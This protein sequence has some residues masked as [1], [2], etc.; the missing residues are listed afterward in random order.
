MKL[1]NSFKSRLSRASTRQLGSQSSTSTGQT[2]LRKEHL[3]RAEKRVLQIKL[4]LLTGLLLTI[5]LILVPAPSLG[6]TQGGTR[7]AAQSPVFHQKFSPTPKPGAACDWNLHGNKL[8]QK[9]S[10]L[11][12]CDRG[13]WTWWKKATS[14][15]SG[16]QGS[17]NSKPD[18][19]P[20]QL[21]S[22][23]GKKV[24]SKSNGTLLCGPK[25]VGRVTTLVWYKSN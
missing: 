16:T 11:Y 18:V 2:I 4:A 9:G 8:V 17:S 5:Q 24:E 3:T 20:G 7:I 1:K 23:V 10:D 19:R 22:P 12:L 6:E 15:S 25:R 21:C 13:V 14:P